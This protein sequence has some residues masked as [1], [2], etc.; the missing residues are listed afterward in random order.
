LVAIYPRLSPRALSS[1]AYSTFSGGVGDRAFGCAG[2]WPRQLRCGQRVQQRRCAPS[3]RTGL[4]AGTRCD[5][6]TSS[7]SSATTGTPVPDWTGPGWTRCAT[8]RPVIDVVWCL[9]PDPFARVY[10]S[11]VIGKR[12][13][14]DTTMIFGRTIALTTHC[15]ARSCRPSTGRFS[16]KQHRAVQAISQVRIIARARSGRSPLSAATGGLADERAA[17]GE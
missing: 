17:A 13:S 9:S 6:M 3:R 10:A 1:R 4:R 11:Q 7:A 8:P 16:L 5:P 2:S 15:P 12:S 14:W